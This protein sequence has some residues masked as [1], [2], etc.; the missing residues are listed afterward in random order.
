MNKTMH[1]ISLVRAAEPVLNG[2]HTRSLGNSS[3]LFGSW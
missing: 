2:V 1:L 3:E